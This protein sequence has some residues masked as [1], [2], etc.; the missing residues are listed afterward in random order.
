M[1]VLHTLRPASCG[2]HEDSCRDRAVVTRSG[3]T[4]VT[5]LADRKNA[6]AATMSRCSLNIT[7]TSAPVAV[8]GAVEIAPA[9]R[10]P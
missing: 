10:P 3:V 1:A 8:D 5:V 2:S 9:G 4:P 6:F 7:S